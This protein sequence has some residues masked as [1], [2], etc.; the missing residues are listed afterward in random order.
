M[1]CE[2]KTPKAGE[3]GMLLLRNRKYGNWNRHV[4]RKGKC[5][6]DRPYRLTGT[7]Q[8]IRLNASRKQ[9]VALRRFFDLQLRG[10]HLTD[11]IFKVW[12]INGQNVVDLV[13]LYLKLNWDA[14]R[15]LP[16]E[17]K[18]VWIPLRIEICRL[19]EG[20]SLCPLEYQLSVGK[21]FPRRPRKCGQLKTRASW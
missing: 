8:I 21:P 7:R 15:F 10:I 6:V 18:T 11:I 9:S 17:S 13:Y 5:E 2:I 19:W 14:G 12:V 20:H 16:D 1:S 3:D 4:Y